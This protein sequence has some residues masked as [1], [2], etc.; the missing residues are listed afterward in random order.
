[1]EAFERVET[2]PD[3]HRA[4]ADHSHRRLVILHSGIVYPSERDPTQ[5]FV[6]LGAL[7][8]ARLL[9]A[10]DVEFRFRASANDAM[11]RVLAAEHAVEDLVSIVQ[12]ISYADA[13]REMMSADGL[14]LMQAANCNAQIPA[15]SYEYL[16]A[17][18][19]ILALTDAAGDTADLMRRSGVAAIAPLDSSSALETALPRFIASL[20][21][22]T[23]RCASSEFVAQCSRR[24]RTQMLAGVLDEIVRAR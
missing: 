3:P 14:L 16:R 8:R 1:D 24:A 10:T 21:D 13:L 15:K 11:L 23:A 4:D 20:R 19:P 7:K 9:S 5:F 22:G 17:A 18:R 6:A 2:P 12:H